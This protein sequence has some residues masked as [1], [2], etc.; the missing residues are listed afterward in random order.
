MP[1]PWLEPE[2]AELLAVVGALGGEASARQVR[3][4][5]FRTPKARLVKLLHE[6]V[7]AGHLVELEHGRFRL[8]SLPR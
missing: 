3:T 6:L 4:R 1:S 8:A 2:L 7:G 5:L